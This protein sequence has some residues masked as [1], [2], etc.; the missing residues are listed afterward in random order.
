MSTR[1]K[2]IVSVVAVAGVI[3]AIVT[4][5]RHNEPPDTAI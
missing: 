5:A 1:A 4:R 3:A 2:V